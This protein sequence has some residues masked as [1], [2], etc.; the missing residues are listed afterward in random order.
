MDAGVV[1]MRIPGIRSAAKAD[2]DEEYIE[3]VRE[4]VKYFRRAALFTAAWAT[5]F[6]G[7]SLAWVLLGSSLASRLGASADRYWVLFEFGMLV[8]MKAGFSPSICL[9]LIVLTK[10]GRLGHEAR[11]QRLALTFYDELAARKGK[12]ATDAVNAEET[13]GSEIEERRIL[14]LR[15]SARRKTDAQ[16][17][18]GIRKWARRSKSLVA[19]QIGLLVIALGV[20]VGWLLL[21]KSAMKTVGLGSTAGGWEG[22]AVGVLWGAVAG[23]ILGLFL[24]PMG[25][26]AVMIHGCRTERLMIRYYD[27]LRRGEGDRGPVALG[28]GP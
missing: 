24:E 14:G 18:E 22:A 27:E 21:W 4:W 9:A 7:A 2:T 15:I 12:R 28:G 23:L 6:C 26:L 11:T 5:L 19:L 17:L 8:G 10:R 1:S 25:R 13:S 20:S 3:S 16:Y